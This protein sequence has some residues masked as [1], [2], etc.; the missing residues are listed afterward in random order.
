MELLASAHISSRLNKSTIQLC[1]VGALDPKKVKGTILVCLRGD[2]AKV[3]KGQQAALACAQLEWFYPTIM[4]LAMKLLLILTSYLLRKLVT[5]M[6]LNS[7]LMLIQQVHLQLP[8]H[9]QRLNWEQSQLQSW[10]PFH[11]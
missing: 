5:L 6:D 2:N 8:L 11:Q 1:K 7:S 3:D 9:I 4:H 10:K